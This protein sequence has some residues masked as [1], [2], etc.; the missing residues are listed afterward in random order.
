MVQL[1][2]VV[3]VLRLLLHWFKAEHFVLALKILQV[4]QCTVERKM[5]LITLR[6]LRFLDLSY[7]NM[8]YDFL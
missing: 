4:R 5:N 6:L 1:C 8:R 3:P 2:Q 7:E